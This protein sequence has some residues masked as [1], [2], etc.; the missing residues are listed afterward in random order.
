MVQEPSIC[1]ILPSTGMHS[2]PMAAV[3]NHQDSVAWINTKELSYS[4]R[5]QESDPG[6]M[7][8][9]PKS[10][11]GCAPAGGWGRHS[12]FAFPAPR[13]HLPPQAGAH[14]SIIKANSSK[15][16][17]SNTA[18]PPRPLLLGLVTRL[19][20]HPNH[21]KDSPHPKVSRLATLTTSATHLHSLARVA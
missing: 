18:P 11:E 12:A 7:G 9:K 5:G 15:S 16:V 3:T 21:Q 10:W 20:V 13:G 19:R 2:F 1:Q 17:S 4:S 14:S 8:T 6:L